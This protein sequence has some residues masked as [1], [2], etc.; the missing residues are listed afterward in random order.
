M[1]KIVG[2]TH[3]S[4]SLNPEWNI[5]CRVCLQE[6]QIRSLFDVCPDSNMSYCEKVMQCSSV[7]IRKDDSLPDQICAQCIRDLD[8]AYR[9]RVSCES[10]DA[11]LQSYRDVVSGR[12]ADREDRDFD[13]Y[14]V[15][16]EIQIPIS[17]DVLYSYK[18]PS[19]LNVKLVPKEKKVWL[20]NN[21]EM[22]M[23]G[24]SAMPP[25]PPPPEDDELADC[26]DPLG[27]V[28]P[29]PLFDDDDID[30]DSLITYDDALPASHASQGGD[31]DDE[32]LDEAK[33]E[34]SK[35]IDGLVDDEED[36]H[37]VDNEGCKPRDDD[38]SADI[39]FNAE[40]VYVDKEDDIL[41]QLASIKQENDAEEWEIIVGI[42]FFFFSIAF[43]GKCYRIL[44]K[45]KVY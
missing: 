42:A 45:N 36:S 5:T 27:D 4:M 22:V 44:F 18:P 23:C 32:D 33:E 43:R 38:S 35:L 29:V 30:N 3:T 19:G 11:I 8:V 26:V 21:G 28:T 40:L 1:K 17:S 13:S 9:F 37:T 24:S 15:S 7:E 2:E 16:S 14:S 39:F 6:G 20:E 10:S 41:N 31:I 25:P 12:D 34:Q